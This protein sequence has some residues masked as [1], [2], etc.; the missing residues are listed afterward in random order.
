METNRG[1]GLPSLARRIGWWTKD[2]SISEDILE[3]SFAT[4]VGV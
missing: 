3:A 2:A 4:F 1:P